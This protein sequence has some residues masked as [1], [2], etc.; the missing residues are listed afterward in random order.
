MFD[1]GVVHI[2]DTVLTVPAPPSDTAIDTGL[3]SLAGSLV[4]SGL[5]QGVDLLTDITIFAPSNAA[6]SAIGSALPGL[7][8]QD[9]VGILEYHVLM[10]QVK[11]ST[12]LTATN[13]MTFVTLAGQN[14]TV[15]KQN[16]QVFVNSAKVL[17]ADI[18][19]SN[20]VVH[21]IDK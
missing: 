12:D 13:E 15:R 20:G 7:Q 2:L 4:T 19:T 11:F 3:T 8:Q 18:L 1:G 6:F 14:I 17:I 16:G 21:V 9:L 5:L 10:N